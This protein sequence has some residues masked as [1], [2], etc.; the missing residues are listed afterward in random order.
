MKA[1]LVQHLLAAALAAAG[2]SLAPSDDAP[3]GTVQ[4]VVGYQSKTII[5]VSAGTLLRAKGFLEHRLAAITAAGGARYQVEWQ[6]Y[7]TG[8]PIT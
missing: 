6:D 2:C 7:D 3:A 5:T 8:A 4:V 1:R